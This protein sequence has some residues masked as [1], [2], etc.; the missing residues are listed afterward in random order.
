MFTRPVSKRAA[1]IARSIP[2]PSTST[3]RLG[4][5]RNA[6]NAIPPKKPPHRV[7]GGQNSLLVGSVVLGATLALG[8]AFGKGESVEHAAHKTLCE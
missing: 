6:S 5:V 3:S 1:R 2:S 8:Y 7:A 4:S